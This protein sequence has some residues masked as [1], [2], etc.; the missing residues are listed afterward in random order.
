MNTALEDMRICNEPPLGATLGLPT[1][2]I[3]LPGNPDQS[4]LLLRMQDLGEY[5][6]PPLTS[7][8]E[9]S[10]AIAVLWQWIEVLKACR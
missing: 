9:D 8:V 10:V 6:M 2:V 4:I 5:R 7:G 3:V 1:P